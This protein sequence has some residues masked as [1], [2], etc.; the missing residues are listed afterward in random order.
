MQSKLLITKTIVFD[1]SLLEDCSYIYCL[2][3]VY[4]DDQRVV[5]DNL[6]L[7]KLSLT[8]IDSYRSMVLDAYLPHFNHVFKSH[9]LFYLSTLGNFRSEFCTGFDTYCNLHLLDKLVAELEIDSLFLYGLNA[10]E[11]QAYELFDWTKNILIE[12]KKIKVRTSKSKRIAL[13]NLFYYLNVFVFSIYLKFFKE[14]KLSNIKDLALVLPPNHLKGEEF[15]HLIYNDSSM[16]YFSMLVS[17]GSH[18]SARFKS[19][20]KNFKKIKNSNKFVINDF[21]L[22]PLKVV[23]GF[24][25]SLSINKK[26]DSIVSAVNKENPLICSLTVQ[27]IELSKFQLNRLLSLEYSLKESLAK[28]KFGNFHSYLFEYNLGRLLLNLVNQKNIPTIGYQHGAISRFKI[29][30]INSPYYLGEQK[31]YNPDTIVCYTY[32]D[33]KLYETFHYLDSNFLHK[34]K[35]NF[36]AKHEIV[37]SEN[38]VICGLHDQSK[39]LL[40][41]KKNLNTPETTVRLHPRAKLDSNELNNVHFIIDTNTSAESSILQHKNIYVSYSTLGLFA[42]KNNK[43]TFLILLN[44]LI[45]QS[46]LFGNKKINY[47]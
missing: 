13:R 31:Q 45:S 11:V 30:N 12:T 5:N 37:Q 7:H 4:L 36:K 25:K 15:N 22:N 29:L 40:F 17:D 38:L 18:T 23:F 46:P 44:G 6:R 33:Q 24:F 41:C 34:P 20:I 32:E 43:N 39:I 14:N 27:D 47:V 10:D 28:I 9:R 8:L 16:N 35:L 1:P 42:L 2:N 19:L 3:G 26:L 21:S